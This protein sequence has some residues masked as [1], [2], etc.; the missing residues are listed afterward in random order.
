MKSDRLIAGAIA[1]V[2]ASVVQ[3]IYGQVVKGLGITDRAFLDF[4]EV[5]LLS[6]T[7]SGFFGIVAGII[8]HLAFG[9]MFGVLFVYLLQ[10]TSSNYLYLKGLGFGIG[11]WFFSLAIGTMFNFP[12]FTETPPVAALVMFVGALLWGAITAFTTK[13]L[14][15]KTDLI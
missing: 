10:I 4:A 8:S 1:G 2:S 3:N 11:I 5:A 15:N 7:Y 14:E 12:M 9:M 6:R 13:I